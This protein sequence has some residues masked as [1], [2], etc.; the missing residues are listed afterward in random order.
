MDQKSLKLKVVYVIFGRLN[1]YG[2]RPNMPHPEMETLENFEKGFSKCLQAIYPSTEKLL[3]K[4]I[5][6]RVIIKMMGELLHSFKNAF[7]ETLP[8]DL[9]SK[10]RLIDKNTALKNIHFPENQDILTAAQ[11]RLKYEELFF[12]QLQLLMKTFNANKK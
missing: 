4:G 11:N 6:Q 1:W 3:S 9:R 8:D 5:S 2:N 7:V 12:I 10:Y